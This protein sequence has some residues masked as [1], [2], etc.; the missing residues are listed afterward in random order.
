MP[1]KK[2]LDMISKTTGAVTKS[3]LERRDVDT[4]AYEITKLTEARI[5]AMRLVSDAVKENSNGL[6]SINYSKDGIM[7]EGATSSNQAQ[8]M[9]EYYIPLETRTQD[10]VRYQDIQKQLNIENVTSIAAEELKNDD[11]VTDK[12]VDKDWTSRFFRYIED[13]SD[14]NIQ[15]IWGRILAGEI[16]QPNTY[17]LRALETLR[18]L[19]TVEAETFVKVSN[20]AIYYGNDVVIFKNDKNEF[21]ESYG[22]G[23]KKVSMLAEAGLINDSSFTSIQ[24]SVSATAA[25]SVYSTS[26]LV[27]LVSR[28]PNQPEK[29]VPVYVLTHVGRQL[30]KLLTPQSPSAYLNAFAAYLSNAQT[31][32][33]YGH[34]LSRSADSVQYKQPL[35]DFPI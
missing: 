2:L 33:Q 7:V 3:Y 26:D 10:R 32:V 9:L 20:L 30:L 29:S 6:T 1:I 5:Q 34:I 28:Q 8:N 17:S 25:Q 18:N 16:R 24:I 15:G 19:S 13:V 23:F 11:F 35:D 12:E 27:I 4:K 21:L 31:T 22:L 14:E